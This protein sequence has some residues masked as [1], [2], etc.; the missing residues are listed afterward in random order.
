[1]R[2][3]DRNEIRRYVINFWA[4]LFTSVS[5]GLILWFMNMPLEILFVVMLAISAA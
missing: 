4:M 3:Q 5:T 1:M 2:Q